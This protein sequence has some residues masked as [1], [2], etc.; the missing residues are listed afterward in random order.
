MHSTPSNPADYPRIYKPLRTS[1]RTGY[2]VEALKRRRER[3]LTPFTVLSCDDN[4]PDNG[5][6]VKNA[7]LGM[8]T[9]ARTRGVDRRARRFPGPVV[10]RIVPGCN[11]R[12]SLVEISQ[13]LG[14]NDPSAISSEPFIQSVVE[15]H[16][17]AGR[18]FLGS[19]RYTN[20]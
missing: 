13:H 4:L 12:E 1:L 11:R 7:V 20:R 14:V 8:A 15:D 18:P 17:V 6:V 5:H 3:G 16:F 10:D 2:L 9:T 19:R